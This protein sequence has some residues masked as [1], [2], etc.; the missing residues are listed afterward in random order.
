MLRKRVVAFKVGLEVLQVVRLH[1][2]RGEGIHQVIHDV[3]G[4]HGV[5][6]V[7]ALAALIGRM[8]AHHR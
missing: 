1:L 5:E 6:I 3:V 2:R 4:I 7:A 8:D